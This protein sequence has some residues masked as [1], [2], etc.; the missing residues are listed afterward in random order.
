MAF[1][2]K[3]NKKFAMNYKKFTFIFEAY[4]TINQLYSCCFNTQKTDNGNDIKLK[5]NISTIY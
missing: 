3:F 5:N 2:L 4:P 1:V